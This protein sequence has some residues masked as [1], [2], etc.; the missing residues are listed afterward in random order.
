MQLATSKK[1]TLE[2]VEYIAKVGTT[3]SQNKMA[4]VNKIYP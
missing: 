2:G 4:E 1:P 3:E